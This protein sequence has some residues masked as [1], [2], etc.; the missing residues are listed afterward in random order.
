MLHVHFEPAGLALEQIEPGLA[1]AGRHGGLLATLDAAP[2]ALVV[3]IALD[4]E[5]CKALGRQLRPPKLKLKPHHALPCLLQFCPEAANIRLG[6]G[7]ILLAYLP[8]ALFGRH[9]HPSASI[10]ARRPGRKSL[11]RW[12][13]RSRIGT[14]LTCPLTM[15]AGGGTAAEALAA[16]VWTLHHLRRISISK[17]SRTTIAIG[18]ICPGH[19]MAQ[20]PVGCRQRLPYPLSEAAARAARPC[21]SPPAGLSAARPE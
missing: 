17:I 18:S 3:A 8:D 14:L 4:L 7:D 16:F 15:R 10:T 13:S 12:P 21:R 1:R 19:W 5:G 2:G 11:A 9:G 20:R 6:L